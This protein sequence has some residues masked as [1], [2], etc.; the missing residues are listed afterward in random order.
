VSRQR[1]VG[2]YLGLAALLLVAARPVEALLVRQRQ[3]KHSGYS[4][5]DFAPRGGRPAVETISTACLGG[6][7]GIIADMLWM[8]VIR[9]EEKGRTYEILALLD[10][11]LQMQPHFISVWAYQAQVLVFDHGSALE[12]PSAQEAYRWVDR[13]IK[14]LEKGSDRNPASYKLHFVLAHVYMRKLSPR[15]V[16]RK[17]W[18]LHLRQMEGQLI[19]SAGND[20]LRRA[21]AR[22][23]RRWYGEVVNSARKAG[24]RDLSP[25]GVRIWYDGTVSGAR[26]GGAAEPVFDPYLGL[27]LAGW[28]YMLAAGKPDVSRPRKLLCERLSIRCLEHMGHWHEAEE[29]WWKFLQGIGGSSDYGFESPTYRA[30]ARFF[31]QFM[32]HRVADLLL[33]RKETESRD[34]HRRMKNYLKKVPDYRDVIVD[35][36]RGL[37]LMQKPGK[38]RELYRVLR[39]KLKDSRTYEEVMKASAE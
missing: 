22:P 36:I 4:L 34:A 6:L 28:H 32:R 10:G 38:S 39:E 16:D 8:R 29:E 5:S 1:S 18:R 25:A 27:K 19:R 3:Q 14:V 26:K 17:T 30:N 33:R 31:R 23:V 35:E 15:N 9:M 11:I 13:G 7:R 20:R 24:V 2:L 21:W 12:N 37:L